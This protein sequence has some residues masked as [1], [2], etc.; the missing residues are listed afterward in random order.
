MS[1]REEVRRLAIGLARREHLP[2]TRE[3]VRE[4]FPAPRAENP[5][6][7]DPWWQ[8]QCLGCLAAMQLLA[9]VPP[10]PEQQQALIELRRAID[11]ALLVLPAP[12]DDEI[13]RKMART[14]APWA[15]SP[16]PVVEAM[17]DLA[18]LTPE[19]VLVD[20]G[21]GDGRIVF[22]AVARGVSWA[23]GIDIDAAM[24]HKSTEYRDA[25]DL[26]ATFFCADLLYYEFARLHPTVVTCYLLT[27][28]MNQ[29]AQKLRQLPPGSRIISHAFP[30]EGWEPART[31]VV[32]GTPIYCWVVP[33]DG[34]ARVV[35][36]AVEGQADRH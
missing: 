1:A 3:N 25:M 34:R 10:G 23:Y 14:L 35:D 2:I 31:A 27:S 17:L 20:L 15:P 22:G 13:D 5:F 30:I 26:K 8:V 4:W 21:S 9:L 12:P 16:A 33:N 7:G 18:E 19:D 6:V 32:D 24:V 11:T 36:A 29:L 28:A